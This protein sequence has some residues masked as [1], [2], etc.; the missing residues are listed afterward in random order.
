MIHDVIFDARGMAQ[1]EFRRDFKSR[2]SILRMGWDG[3]KTYTGADKAMHRLAVNRG[4]SLLGGSNYQH[5]TQTMIPT[6][7]DAAHRWGL[8][9]ELRVGDRLVLLR[10]LPR[11]NQ[12]GCQFAYCRSGDAPQ[13]I[14]AISAS[15]GWFDEP[16]AFKRSDADASQ[17]A[18]IQFMGRIR[19]SDE[20]PGIDWTGT[21]EGD[22]TR[23]YALQ[24]SGRDDVAVA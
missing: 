9:P 20:L 19:G 16:A 17:D 14:R 21:N 6:L 2:H 15:A 3:G 23:F 11:A 12:F 18:F 4:P 1:Y 5:L 7:I 24:T 10:G 22:G 13:S 8:E